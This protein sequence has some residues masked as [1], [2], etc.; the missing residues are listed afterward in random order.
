[1]LHRVEIENFYSIHDRQVID[2]TVAANAPDE[3]G[4]FAPLW[5][6]S[7]EKAP[8]VIALFGPNAS[9]KSTV[10]K[11][12]SFIK[13]FAKDSFSAPRGSRMPFDR[14][15][16]EEM[17]VAPTRIAI[18]LSGIEDIEKVDDPDAAQ[19][20]YAYEFVIGGRDGHQTVD[21]EALYY[22]PSTASRKVRLFERNAAGEVAASKPFGLSGYRQALE[23]V[24]R[25]DASVISTL[26]Q[27]DHPYA[28]LLWQTASLVVSN[29]LIEKF[30]GTDDT[31]VRHYA[32]N[33]DL[34]AVFNREIQRID[35]GI[36]EMRIEQG[37]NG[38]IALFE[39]E[40]LAVPMPIIYE[41]HG[42]RQFIRLYPFIL[43]AL[44][45]GGIAVLDELDATI[46]P[47]LLPEI[48]RWFYDS[49]RNPHNAQLWMSCHNPS[50]LEDFLKEEVL[51]CDKDYQGR[52]T[53]YGLRDIQS[54]KRSDNYYRKYLG[55]SFGAVPKIG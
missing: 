40:G 21:H 12:L 52:T 17:L 22:W 20:R 7:N 3:P 31:A 50:L 43:G 55:G 46:H 45:S 24:L 18:Q 38:P 13:W 8:K 5:R 48:L 51:F 35:V 32:G 26:A 41:S 14:F 25:P 39:H 10:S 33:P 29:I 54:V 19:C 27:L 49:E 15:N 53:V 30:D 9:G 47:L 11:A 28:K 16:S 36:R 6:G 42:T 1:M 23:K 37:H 34:V 4:R 2:L 44:Q